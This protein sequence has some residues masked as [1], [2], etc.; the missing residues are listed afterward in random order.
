MRPSYLE[1]VD[2]GELAK[3]AEALRRLQSPCR[4]CPRECGAERAAGETG[5]CGCGQTALV[6]GVAPHFGEEAPLVGV[7]GSGTI[8]LAG[9]NMGC[10][11]CQN[12]EISHGRQGRPTSPAGLARSMLW[13]QDSGCQ[14]INFVTPTHFAPQIV[15]AIALA[16]ADGLRLPVVWNCGGYESLEAL[17]LLAGIVDIYMPDMKYSDATAAR[18]LS[19][20]AGYPQH[21]RAAVRAMHEQVGDLGID[22]RGVAVRGLLVRHLVLPGGRA[23]SDRVMEFLGRLSTATYVNIMD[24]YRPCYRAGF[25]PPLDRPITKREF[26]AALDCAAQN[27]LTRIDKVR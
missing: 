10:L 8:F 24:Q 3:R 1:L 7:G 13:L 22:E 14:N 4:L 16:A 12:H 20:A 21:N 6:A 26:S 9:C 23:G 19:G 27:G 2:G 17:A 18:E 15:E 5:F 25:H 11:Y